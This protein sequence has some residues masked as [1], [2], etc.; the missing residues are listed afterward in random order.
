MLKQGFRLHS[1]RSLLWLVAGGFFMLTLDATVVTTALP[2][3]ARSLGESPLRMQSVIV[4][5]V[6]TMALLI[7][8]SGWIADRFGTRRVYITAIGLFTFGSLC[9]GMAQS[10]EQL[11]AARVLQGLGSALMLPVGRLAVIRVFTGNRLLPAIS[12]VTIPSLIGPLIG[13][14]LGGWLVQIASWQWIFLVNIP[15]G[16]IGVLGAWMYMPGRPLSGLGPFDFAGYALLALGMLCVTLALD[17]VA[18]FGFGWEIALTLIMLGSA[19]LAGYWRHAM[20]H[21]NPL[22]PPTLFRVASLRI[23]LWGNFVARLGCSSTPYLLPLYFQ[24][25]Q[26][27]SPLN[28]GL[29]MLPIAMAGMVVKPLAN[30]LVTR[31]GY[32]NVLINNTLLVSLTIASFAMGRGPRTLWLQLPALLFFGAFNSLQLT[33]MSTL[34]LKDLAPQQTSSGNSTLTMVQMLAMGMGVSGAGG[35]LV[36]FSHLFASDAEVT[37]LT[38]RTTFVCMG[39]VTF[40]SAAIFWRLN[41]DALKPSLTRLG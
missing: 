13:P 34:T 24:V 39:A 29:L 18:S 5:Y 23:G 22:F 26:G 33:A 10:S 16:F 28:A 6:M 30:R 8:A 37:L 19:N 15:V 38:F 41:N 20:R 17:G 21:R 2:A 1:D 27:Y 12:F 36:L 14:A 31:F 7:P 9:C 40:L 11:I 25:C 3:M 35:L 32:R 4:A